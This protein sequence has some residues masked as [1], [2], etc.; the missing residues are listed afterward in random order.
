M[1][2]RIFV[3]VDGGQVASHHWIP[4]PTGYLRA[5]HVWQWSLIANNIQ[6]LWS[7]AFHN[8]FIRELLERT[9]NKLVC[10]YHVHRVR[11][12]LGHASAGW[13]TC[14]CG[15]LFGSLLSL[16]ETHATHG[17]RRTNLRKFA[18]PRTDAARWFLGD[19]HG[20]SSCDWLK[21]WVLMGNHPLCCWWN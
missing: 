14:S 12:V 17:G 5:K 9:Y 3:M 21:P 18:L 6:Q 20:R 7:T 16:L 19:F 4:Q 8:W 10:L 11:H 13:W 1:L 2:S 15:A